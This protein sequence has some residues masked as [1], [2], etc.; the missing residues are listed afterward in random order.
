MQRETIAPLRFKL[1]HQASKA[2]KHNQK[3]AD[4][5]PTF[6]RKDNGQ[7]V[8]LLD[9]R[10]L[11]VIGLGLGSCWDAAVA[12]ATFVGKGQWLAFFLH[13]AI[14]AF[15]QVGHQVHNRIGRNHQAIGRGGF[16]SKVVGI[17]HFVVVGIFEEFIDIHVFNRS[18]LQRRDVDLRP[19]G[20]VAK[21]ADLRR[22]VSSEANKGNQIQLVVA[23]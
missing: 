13:H 1:F 11:H 5:R 2:W 10:Q 19:R 7:R 3:K 20:I 15:I 17:E 18:V 6:S 9:D 22:D 12:A 8:L 23:K 16:R 14:A 21:S 4:L